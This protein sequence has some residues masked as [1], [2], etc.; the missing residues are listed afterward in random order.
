MNVLTKKKKK[1]YF[2]SIIKRNRD[3]VWNSKKEVVK[4]C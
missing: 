1:R 2:Y 4:S 3:E